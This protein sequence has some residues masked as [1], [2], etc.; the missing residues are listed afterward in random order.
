[1]A[2][3]SERH[4]RKVPLSLPPE[5]DILDAL[6]AEVTSVYGADARAVRLTIKRAQKSVYRLRVG[7]EAPGVEAEMRV[8]GK[9]FRPEFRIERM[10][11]AHAWMNAAGL[12]TGSPGGVAVPRVYGVARN[13]LLMEHIEGETLRSRFL[14]L[15]DLALAETLARA[16][17][18]LHAVPPPEGNVRA[19]TDRLLLHPTLLS[20]LG[21]ERP[22]LRSQADDLVVAAAGLLDRL[23]PEEHTAIHGDFHWGQV[24]VTDDG[25][26]C[27]IDITPG[28]S[29][30]PAMDVG[31]LLGQL[32][33]HRDAAWF[34]GFHDAFLDGYLELRPAVSRRRIAVHQAL[35]LVRIGAKYAIGE[36][37][38]EH[39]SAEAMFERAARLLA[40]AAEAAAL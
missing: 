35:T 34:G 8:V 19:A 25:V 15:G 18:A 2:T 5:G 12:Q 7:I 17:A 9:L 20:R 26:A 14:A 3:K 1:M 30:D 37:E 29:G 4:D 21:T 28:W 40:E 23:G 16:L 6:R 22:A 27:L 32:E 24:L 33:K 10:V 31:N 11:A 39:M 36:P 13:M 38:E